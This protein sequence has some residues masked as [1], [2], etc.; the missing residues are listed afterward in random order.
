MKKTRSPSI[1]SVTRNTHLLCACVSTM[2]SCDASVRVL[3]RSDSVIGEE[4]MASASRQSAAASLM[5]RS[6][7]AWSVSSTF[8]ARRRCFVSPFT[9]SNAF[10]FFSK[11]PSSCNPDLSAPPSLPSSMKT[12]TTLVLQFIQ[13]SLDPFA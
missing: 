6:H 10:D 1:F 3:P 4:A 9:I 11:Q 7:I 5:V 13:V 12:S 2:S 8:G